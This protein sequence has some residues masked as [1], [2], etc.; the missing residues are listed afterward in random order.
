[1]NIQERDSILAEIA[2]L[3]NFNFFETIREKN[4]DTDLTAIRVGEQSIEKVAFLWERVLTQLENEL[5]SDNYFVL[6]IAVN[7]H[8]Y[9]GNFNL[10][11][12]LQNLKA[13]LEANNLPT[14]FK[15]LTNNIKYQI[16]WGFWD[17]S[18]RKVHNASD[19]DLI[20]FSK[21]LE[22][23][24]EHLKNEVNKLN[25]KKTE[26][27]KLQEELNVFYQTKQKEL[28]EI[29]SSLISSRQKK[30]EINTLLIQANELNTK[31]TSILDNQT[32]AYTDSKTNIANQEKEIADIKTKFKEDTKAELSSFAEKQKNTDDYLAL[33]KEQDEN[34][35]SQLKFI[36]EQKEFIE[37]KR[38]ELIK[39]TGFAADTV[40]AHSF[41]KRAKDIEKGVNRW[42]W[43]SGVLTVLTVLWIF[44]LITNFCTD[45]KIE[46]KWDSF[47]LNFF[48]TSPFFVALGFALAQYSRERSLW[49]EYA[50][51]AAV[52]LTINPYADKLDGTGENKLK[53]QLIVDSIMN[54]Y[55]KPKGMYEKGGNPTS[56]GLKTIINNV[57]GDKEK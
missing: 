41:D 35:K 40:L 47:L 6:P 3:K 21:E 37:Q 12:N 46:P 8:L 7:N 1:M 39:L 33:L 13:S 2:A 4:P 54:V 56:D 48:K 9:I 51:K 22:L 32:K 36:S 14:L 24:K 28:Q 57:K 31:I 50:F 20:A 55:S 10:L 19:V 34:Y 25:K 17:K 30:D 5:L 52:A 11:N 45:F 26:F 23:L 43:I 38:N 42:M 49:E 27:E 16:E 53:Q 15:G 44:L 29:T 18:E